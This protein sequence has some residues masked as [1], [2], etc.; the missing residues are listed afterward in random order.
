MGEERPGARH[1][2][3]RSRGFSSALFCRN[4]GGFFREILV[5]FWSL[6]VNLAPLQFRAGR[7]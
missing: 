5:A 4:E 3:A 2:N 7:K 1:L 6:I